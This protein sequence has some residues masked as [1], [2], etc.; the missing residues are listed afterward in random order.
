MIRITAR[1]VLLAAISAQLFAAAAAT[2]PTDPPK[3]YRVLGADKKRVAII[4]EK[5]EIEWEIANPDAREVHDIQLLDN[6]NILFQTGYTT[7][8]EVNRDRPLDQTQDRVC[9]GHF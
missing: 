6:G 4:N 7:V 1:I 8:V 3:G 9:G 2:R 5:G